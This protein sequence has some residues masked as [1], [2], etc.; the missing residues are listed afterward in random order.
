MKLARYFLALMI[1]TSLLVLVSCGSKENKTD[2]SNE[3]TQAQE[4]LE[5]EIK[6]VV[7]Q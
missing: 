3:F 2:G 6:T 5:G 7:Y 1:T 4:S